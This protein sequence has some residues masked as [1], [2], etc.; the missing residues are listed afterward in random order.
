MKQDSNAA[1]RRIAD[2]SDD[3]KPREKALAKGIRVLS[4]AELLALLI[5]GGVPGKSAIDLAREILDACD[6]SLSQLS[7][8]SIQAISRRFVGIGPAKATTIA[9]AL[10]IGARSGSAEEEVSVIRQASD[11]YRCLL[12]KMR[13]LPH[14]EFWTIFLRRNNSVIIC[15]QISSGGSSATYVEPRMIVKKA[16][17]N[18][19]SA[20]ILGHNHPSGNLR[21]SSQDDALTKK[22]K[23][24]AALL[25]ITVHDHIIVT[26]SGFY[27]YA[28][29][30][31]L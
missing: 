21:P 27:S 3:D 15:E 6:N 14:E 31:R 9:A 7:Q 12:P 28:E 19:A 30:G 2:L 26:P 17:D 8:M 13:N 11:A 23:E 10:E 29:E 20:I 1:S 24:A 18:M 25:D 4:D 22:I 5:G 16:L